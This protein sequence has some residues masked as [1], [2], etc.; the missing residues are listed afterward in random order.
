MMMM[1]MMWFKVI[2]FI[3]LILDINLNLYTDCYVIPSTIVQFAGTDNSSSSS[4][5]SISSPSIS[6]PIQIVINAADDN[7]HDANNN[8]DNKNDNNNNNFHI[9]YV[10][11]TIYYDEIHQDLVIFNFCKEYSLSITHHFH[12]VI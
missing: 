7:V 4:P 5:Y 6:L 8:D 1:M 11:I 9:S 10:N 3:I 2:A 12:E